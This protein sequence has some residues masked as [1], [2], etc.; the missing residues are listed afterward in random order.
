VKM[1]KIDTE[2][3]LIFMACFGMRLL[4]SVQRDISV[5]NS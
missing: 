1:Q 5:L 3:I 2:A 4:K